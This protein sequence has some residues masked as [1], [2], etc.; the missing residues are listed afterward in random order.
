VRKDVNIGFD[1]TDPNN[2]RVVPYAKKYKSVHTVQFQTGSNFL[3]Y[4][5]ADVKLM[6]AECLNEQ[7]F[8]ANGEAFT[9]LNEVRT[10]AGVAS[11]STT[12]TDPLLRVS[13][14][15]EFR[16]AIAS[17]R[18]LEFAFENHRWFD[19]LRTDKATAVMQAH[20]TREKAGKT[21]VASTAYQTIPTVFPYP[22]AELNLLNQ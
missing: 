21:Y 17:E 16:T 5:Y 22:Q 14:Q 9:L 20:G 4:R 13:T 12:A 15:D 11:K 7:G 10:R 6:L 18:Q 8:V 3:V 19:L 2:G 1:F